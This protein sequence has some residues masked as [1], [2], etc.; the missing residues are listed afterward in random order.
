MA[1]NWTRLV[2]ALLVC[3]ALPGLWPS[4]VQAL[5]NISLYALFKDKA[6]VVIDGTRRVLVRGEVSPEGVRLVGTDTRAEEAVVEIDGRRET[7]K[8]GVVIA[9]FQSVALPSVVLYADTSGFFRAPGS[10]NGT[11]VTFLV[12]TGA[13]T[14]AINS[15]LA[16]RIGIDYR[17]RGQP[18]LA[19][20]ASGYAR[21]YGIKL[22]TVKVGEIVLRNVDAAVIEGRQPE[23]PLLGMSFLG[24]LEMKRDGDK[25]EL[26]KKY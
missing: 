10:I 4:P 5:E 11:A 19:T 23:T 1:V 17:K 14:I 3:G 8:L 26:I 16:Q 7:L 15:T 2:S 18:G 21:F 9:H 22:D 25:M 24:G 6:I 20:T 12:D 13:N